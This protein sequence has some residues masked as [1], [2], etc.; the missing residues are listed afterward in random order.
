MH[1]GDTVIFWLDQWQLGNNA[2]LMQHLFPRL[3]SFVIDDT[4][5]I[6]DMMEL[7]DPTDK[8]HLPLSAEA[9]EEFN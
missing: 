4:L 9:F 6:K 8:L 3:H 7:S 1:A 2:V 5:T